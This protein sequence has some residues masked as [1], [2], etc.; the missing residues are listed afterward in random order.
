MHD[1]TDTDTDTHTIAQLFT[2]RAAVSGAAVAAVCGAESITYDELERRSNQLGHHLRSLGV[3]PESLV[4]ICIERGCDQVV[5]MLAVWKA[6]GAYVPMDP[7]HPADRLA[8][9][10]ADAGMSAVISQES[11]RERLPATVPVVCPAEVAE[12]AGLPTDVPRSGAGADDLAYVIYTS[13]STGTPRGVCTEHRQAAWFATCHGVGVTTPDDVVLS[14]CAVTFD[15]SVY[16]IWGTLLAG[17]RV[18]LLPTKAFPDAATLTGLVRRHGVTRLWM[19]PALLNALAGDPALALDGVRHVVTGGERPSAP[20]WRTFLTRFEGTLWNAYGTTE[21]TGWSLLYPADSAS[22]LP[23]GIPAGRPLV[24]VRV[25]LLD[26]DG[27]AIPDGAVG[28][29]CIEGPGV[30]RGYLGDEELT[31]RRFAVRQGKR[32]YRTGDL[33]RWVADGLLELIGRADQQV[34]VRGYRVELGEIETALTRCAQVEQSCVVMHEI[35]PEDRRLAAYL[36][37]AQ[38]A[39][40]VAQANRGFIASRTAQFA[41]LR[42]VRS[43]DAAFNTAGWTDPV[44]GEQLS[45]DLVREWTV[46]TVRLLAGDY[47]SVWEIGCGHGLV[48]WRLAPRSATYLG[49]DLVIPDQLRD[50][51]PQAFGKVRLEER[52][53]ADFDGV[54]EREHDLVVLNSVAQ[55]FPD[56]AYL[57]TVLEGCVD[58]TA[59]GG[60]IF[61]GDIRTGVLSENAPHELAVDPA[62]FTAFGASHPRVRGTHTLPRE[63]CD[64]EWTRHRYDVVLEI[65]ADGPAQPDGGGQETAGGGTASP[66][67]HWRKQ[68]VTRAARRHAQETLPAHMVPAIFTVLPE[69][70]LSAHGKVDR[71]A[72]PAPA[73]DTEADAGV[74]PRNALEEALAEVWSEVLRAPVPHVHCNFFE[75]LG[76][77]SL[78][79]LRVVTVAKKR[80][81]AIA[82]M[83]LFKHS[84]IAAL[85]EAQ[86]E[87][88]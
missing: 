6:G 47:R 74:Q 30:A 82:V 88:K 60:R 35:S 84:T 38:G 41:G 86:R 17:G 34:Q 39:E 22:D 13:G 62:W 1:L 69:L 57:R 79:A 12:L 37:P 5:A 81:L 27:R 76:G 80:G 64:A 52:E 50:T 14:T 4:G 43:P 54:P 33:G 45:A 48:L 53:A 32:L 71:N 44:T 15:V 66:L 23:G 26:E 61:L 19:P 72:L 58:A 11:L 63:G 85:A 87:P 2:R 73:F 10:V 8:R 49:T 83:D 78:L 68:D 7:D 24:D 65:G 36:V 75:D 29:V 46:Q 9:L 55:Y 16:E 3:S 28:E 56:Y 31:D 77:D 51:A 67:L 59:E 42:A 18:V 21:S 40:A 25:Y 70:P 20:H